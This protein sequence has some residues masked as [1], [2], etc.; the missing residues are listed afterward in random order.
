MGI[1]AEWMMMSEL[2]FQFA[3]LIVTA[4]LAVH[5]IAASFQL[6]HLVI[7]GLRVRAVPGIAPLAALWQTLGITFAL[8]GFVIHDTQFVIFGTLFLALRV[9][10]QPLGAPSW[11]RGIELPL[12]VLAVL[13]LGFVA[14]LRILSVVTL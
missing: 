9:V 1:G 5:G 2:F 12:L 10:L 8:C 14:V 6:G 13:S 7:D 3:A 4:T 11:D